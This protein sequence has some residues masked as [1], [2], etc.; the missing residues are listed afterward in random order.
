MRNS[1]IWLVG[2]SLIL[3]TTVVMAEDVKYVN[4]EGV[5]VVFGDVQGNPTTIEPYLEHTRDVQKHGKKSVK[6]VDGQTQI[7]YVMPDGTRTGFR[8]MDGKHMTWEE[9]LEHL[10]D[11]Q[12]N[13]KEIP[14]SQDT[15][16]KM[17]RISND[18]PQQQ[19]MTQSG[20]IIAGHLPIPTMTK[21][22][23]DKFYGERGVTMVDSFDDAKKLPSGTPYKIRRRANRNEADEK[24]E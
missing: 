11:I 19:S 23:E 17:R 24:E 5:T 21:E 15:S 12:T 10:K 9:N 14:M 13:Y 22:E 8:D 16:I 3:F 20:G 7:E 2:I 6:E 18:S 4:P 1:M